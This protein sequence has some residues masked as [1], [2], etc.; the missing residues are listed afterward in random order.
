MGSG[1]RWPFDLE[2]MG[3]LVISECMKVR[4][5]TSRATDILPVNLVTPKGDVPV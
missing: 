1:S 2:V 3:K 5:E 4:C